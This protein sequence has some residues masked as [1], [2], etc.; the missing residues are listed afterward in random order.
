MNDSTEKP[1]LDSE[2]I[3]TDPTL[4]PVKSES[5]SPT[6]ARTDR[7]MTEEW[8]AKASKEIAESLIKKFETCPEFLRIT[9]NLLKTTAR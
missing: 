4:E 2:L 9:N 7:E 5:F 3:D 8:I 6:P 1:K